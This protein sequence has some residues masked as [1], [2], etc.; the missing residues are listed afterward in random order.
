MGFSTANVLLNNGL[1][2]AKV[3]SLHETQFAYAESFMDVHIN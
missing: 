3:Y 1:V 2:L